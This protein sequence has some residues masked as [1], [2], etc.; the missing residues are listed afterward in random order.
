MTK[1]CVLYCTC[2]CCQ[3]AG[4]QLIG[5][6]IEKH[7]QLYEPTS[8]IFSPD[9]VMFIPGFYA[10]QIKFI[11]LI[12]NLYV[13]LYQVAPWFIPWNVSAYYLSVLF[14]AGTI[15]QQLFNLLYSRINIFKLKICWTNV[16]SVI[17]SIV[18]YSATM[19]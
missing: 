15:G 11:Y 9:C 10:I 14:F 1:V 17:V 2:C 16:P 7:M 18:Q 5:W 4:Y 13:D 12:W 6:L 19:L 3:F 8:V